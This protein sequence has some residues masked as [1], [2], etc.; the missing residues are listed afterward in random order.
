MHNKRPKSNVLTMQMAPKDEALFLW[1]INHVELNAFP[2]KF[3]GNYLFSKEK[4]P[5]R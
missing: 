1:S 3:I 4:I 5:K 2:A